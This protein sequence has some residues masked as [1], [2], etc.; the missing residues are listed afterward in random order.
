M[1]LVVVLRPTVY[2]EQKEAAR[3]MRRYPWMR[4]SSQEKTWRSLMKNSAQWHWRTEER[5]MESRMD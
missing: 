3:K 4:T 5:E 2:Q 1:E